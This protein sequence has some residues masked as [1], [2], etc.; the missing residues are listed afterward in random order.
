MAWRTFW[1]Q[2]SWYYDFFPFYCLATANVFCSRVAIEWLFRITYS[3]ANN[4]MTMSSVHIHIHIRSNQDRVSQIK[5]LITRWLLLKSKKKCV[6]LKSFVND[7]T[8]ET[9]IHWKHENQNDKFWNS[10]KKRKTFDRNKQRKIKEWIER[11]TW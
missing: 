6:A 4:L 9:L 11:Q 3:L 5:K 8:S 7:H 2:F 1:I 10:G